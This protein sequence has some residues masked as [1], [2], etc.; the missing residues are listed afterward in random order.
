V[1]DLAVNNPYWWCPGKV[2]EE[3]WVGWMSSTS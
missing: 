2:E 1:H 3:I